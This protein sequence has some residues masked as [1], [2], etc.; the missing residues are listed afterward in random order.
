MKWD[1]YILV[2]NRFSASQSCSFAQ[3]K[4]DFG[5]KNDHSIIC[6]CILLDEIETRLDEMA[7]WLL[8]V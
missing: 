5:P 1:M 6:L 8:L 4:K 7:Q 3:L 2:L